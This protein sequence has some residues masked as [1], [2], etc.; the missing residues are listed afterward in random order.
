MRGLKKVMCLCF[1]SLFS[2]DGKGYSGASYPP[3]GVRE[4][5]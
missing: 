2:P 3:V 1:V 4:G 5:Q